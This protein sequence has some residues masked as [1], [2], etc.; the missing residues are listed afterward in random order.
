MAIIKTAWF[1]N[2]G[3]KK[4]KQTIN[5]ETTPSVCKNLIFD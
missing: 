1:R 3:Y 2:R 5:S 4:I